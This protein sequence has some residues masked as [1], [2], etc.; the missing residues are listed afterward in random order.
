MTTRRSFFRRVAAFA[1]TIA[2]APQI[3]FRAPVK[4]ALDLDA[5]LMD[6]RRIKFQRIAGDTGGDTIDIVTDQKTATEIQALMIRY[7][8]RRETA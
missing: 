5:L 2:L 4:P 1:A 6:L 7:Y 3:A 8:E